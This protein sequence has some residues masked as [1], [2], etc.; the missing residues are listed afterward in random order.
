MTSSGVLFETWGQPGHASIRLWASCTQF[1]EFILYTIRMFWALQL[2]CTS[3]GETQ[4]IF[5]TMFQK[6]NRHVL[7]GFST[8][9]LPPTPQNPLRK[10]L[11]ARAHSGPG[12]PRLNRMAQ[13][14]HPSLVIGLPRY[15]DPARIVVPGYNNLLVYGWLRAYFYI[16]LDDRRPRIFSRA[17]AIL[18]A[19]LLRN[20]G[21]VPWNTLKYRLLR[22][23]EK[24]RIRYVSESGYY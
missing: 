23:L 8:R 18:F 4:S 20:P 13:V 11:L 3:L 10:P 19:T 21:G 12:S 7:I 24:K 17:S 5:P 15:D 2:C 6:H 16:V 1:M 22:G 14:P 9:Q